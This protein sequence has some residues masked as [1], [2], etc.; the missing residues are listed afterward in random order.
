MSLKAEQPNL[1]NYQMD[2]NEEL[3]K[4]LLRLSYKY[5]KIGKDLEAQGDSLCLQDKKDDGHLVYKKA[6]IEFEKSVQVAPE[7]QASVNSFARI[8]AKLIRGMTV[9][10]EPNVDQDGNQVEEASITFT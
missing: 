4:F 8:Q 3:E 7:E 10:T 2:V 6:K 9:V 1:V 5:Y